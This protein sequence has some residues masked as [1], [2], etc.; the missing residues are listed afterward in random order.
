[1]DEKRSVGTTSG[2]GNLHADVDPQFVREACRQTRGHHISTPYLSSLIL[3]C[4]LT[5]INQPQGRHFE[6]RIN[7]NY[8]QNVFHPPEIHKS[9]VLLYPRQ[10]LLQGCVDL[11]VKEYFSPSGWLASLACIYFQSFIG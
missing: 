6:Q 1:M 9:H 5:L 2:S 3:Q 4:R 11:L 7:I 8:H 10:S